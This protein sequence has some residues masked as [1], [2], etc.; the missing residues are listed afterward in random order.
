MQFV[1]SKLKRFDFHRKTVNEVNDKTLSGAIITLISGCIILYLLYSNIAEYFSTSQINHMMPDTTVG[2][3]DVEL[4]FL[5]SFD[6]VKCD[7]ISFKQEVVRGTLHTHSPELF[8][9]KPLHTSGCQVS[10]EVITDKVGGNFMLVVKPLPS[11]HSQE[12]EDRLKMSRQFPGL[13]QLTQKKPP[14]LNHIVESLE[15]DPIPSRTKTHY[16]YLHEPLKGE[17]NHPPSS[18]GIYHYGIQ[19]VPT[20]HNFLNGSISHSNQYSFT[21]R[22]VEAQNVA[23]GVTLNGQQFKDNFGIVFTYE[24]YPVMLVVEETSES[25]FWFLTNF[26]AVIG[27]TITI[28]GLFDGLIYKANKAR[29]G[30]KD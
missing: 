11:E 22:S 9:K 30:K 18:T 15:F 16:V 5:V 7:D 19:V 3:E 10:G 29:L 21:E 12:E 4:K 25:F 8:L 13:V 14:N 17:M 6:D 24:F 2:T 27:G 20:E 1:S 26:C 28:L 23:F